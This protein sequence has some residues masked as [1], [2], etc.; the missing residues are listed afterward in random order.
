MCRA[1]SYVLETQDTQEL[2][3]EK[4]SVMSIVTAQHDKYRTESVMGKETLL[5]PGAWEDEACGLPALGRWTQGWGK[6]VRGVSGN[7]KSLH[8][9]EP[10]FSS[11]VQWRDGS[12]YFIRLFV[13]RARESSLG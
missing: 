9:P 10:R 12:S 3:D 7:D 8:R 2:S 1:T 11:S 4:E 13:V 6:D 5:S